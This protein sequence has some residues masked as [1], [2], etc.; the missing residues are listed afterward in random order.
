MNTVKISIDDI[1][2]NHDQYTLESLEAE[3]ETT[4]TKE[5]IV[6]AVKSLIS[7]AIDQHEE[8]EDENCDIDYDECHNESEEEYFTDE[9]REYYVRFLLLKK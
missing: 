5:E 6:E 2:F 7:T 1:S 3:Y 4:R 9:T 8:Y